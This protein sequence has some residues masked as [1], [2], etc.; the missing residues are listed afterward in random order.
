MRAPEILRLSHT[1]QGVQQTQEW[2]R[3]HRHGQWEKLLIELTY[4]EFVAVVDAILKY[5]LYGLCG[6][7]DWAQR[8]DGLAPWPPNEKPL[9]PKKPIS[10][11]ESWEKFLKE[12]ARDLWQ[13]HVEQIKR[14]ARKMLDLDV[15]GENRG[16]GG[17]GGGEGFGLSGL[18]FEYNASDSFKISLEYKPDV[19]LNGFR[20]K[21][22]NGML[23]CEIKWKFW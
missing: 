2:E 8:P 4:Y 5:D 21:F 20:P 15:R 10:S 1:V 9:F 7:D 18:G 6:F 23:E 17:G 19:N 11:D 16:G 12:I 22:D 13:T 3:R 14:E